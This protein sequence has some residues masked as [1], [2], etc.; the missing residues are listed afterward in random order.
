MTNHRRVHLDRRSRAAGATFNEILFRQVT[1]TASTP[2]EV[3]VLSK[4]DVFHRLSRAAREALRTAAHGHEESVVDLD[5]FH[6]TDKWTKYKQRVLHEHMNHDRLAKILVQSPRSNTA[7]DRLEQRKTKPKRTPR[8][9]ASAVPERAATN[10]EAHRHHGNSYDETLA[11]TPRDGGVLPAKSMLVSANEFLLL[12]PHD[13]AAVRARASTRT[14]GHFVST[15]NADAPPSGARRAQLDDVLHAERARHVQVLNEG[16]PLA[17]FDL[18]AIKQQEKKHHSEARGRAASTRR[19]LLIGASPLVAAPASSPTFGLSSLE[20]PVPALA[21]SNKLAHKVAAN[22]LNQLGHENF[23]FSRPVRLGANGDDA[24]ARG[25]HRS[26]HCRKD[27]S[28]DDDSSS[29][30]RHATAALNAEAEQLCDGEFV[31]VSFSV[32][33]SSGS[34]S[35][36]SVTKRD[37]ADASVRSLQSPLIQVLAAV[38]SLT[39]AREV[40][41]REEAVDALA[42]CASSTSDG[43]AVSEPGAST[44]ATTFFVVP[45]RK[46]AVLP[47]ANRPRGT[48]EQLQRELVERF[49]RATTAPSASSTGPSLHSRRPS[50][51]GLLSSSS[52]PGGSSF[53]ERSIATAPTAAP[54]LEAHGL[55]ASFQK[56][57]FTTSELREITA[58]RDSAVR[59]STADS[60]RTEACPT[61]AV[62]KPQLEQHQ[63]ARPRLFAVVSLVL[64]KHEI[65]NS[66]CEEPFMCVHQL[67]TSEA[68]A[69]DAALHMTTQHF[70]NALVCVLPVGQRVHLEDAYDWCVQVE[71][72][73]RERRSAS[74]ASAALSPNRVKAQHAVPH[75]PTSPPPR[76]A[77]RRTNSK[78]SGTVAH[79]SPLRIHIAGAA[80]APHGSAEWQVEREK[81]HRLHQFIC[82]RLG[83]RATADRERRERQE[84]T[85]FTPKPLLTLEDK[86]TTL[87]EYLETANAAAA[88]ARSGGGGGLALGK[89]RQMKRFGSIMRARINSTLA[90]SG[91]SPTLPASSSPSSTSPTTSPSSLSSAGAPASSPLAVSTVP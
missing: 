32:A 25:W 48:E 81:A 34:H 59:E 13:S 89:Y 60:A 12:P 16:N 7:V 86:L 79:P 18:Q 44:A 53:P 72:D 57:V 39:H 47:R 51:V 21:P 6:K 65:E 90:T 75:P 36:D 10:Q 58:A 37:G 70:R 42:R 43:D 26:H 15:F 54:V 38:T 41:L 80:A 19:T 3:L 73:R 78:A 50:T 66:V 55:F 64:S 17:Y 33:S 14:I 69:T 4:Y 84:A 35:S 24:L 20:S 68:Q 23:V 83:Q 61:A 85:G 11:S 29:A 1:V 40:A 31:V 27:C 52:P 74:Y 82:S 30:S 2:V 9:V 77:M 63:G 87:H 71:S 28:D 91:L 45:K 46:Y 8:D 88:S 49:G 56:I 5:R 22:V 62:T 76:M 67:F